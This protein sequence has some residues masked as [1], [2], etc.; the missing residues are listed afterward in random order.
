MEPCA[1]KEYAEACC[2][3]ANNYGDN[4]WKKGMPDSVIINHA[5]AHLMKYMDG[6]RSEPHC[7][8]VM[9][10]MAALIWNRENG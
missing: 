3:G 9:W 1:L 7:G 5:I 8:K 4:N 10:A 2:E 6:D